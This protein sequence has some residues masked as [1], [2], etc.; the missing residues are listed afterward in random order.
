MAGIRSARRWPSAA[1]AVPAWKLDLEWCGGKDRGRFRKGRCHQGPRNSSARE[2]LPPSSSDHVCST[3]ASAPSTIHWL[4]VSTVVPRPSCP[5][6]GLGQTSVAK[7]PLSSSWDGGILRPW[8]ASA[9][10]VPALPSSSPQGPGLG[11]LGAGQCSTLEGLPPAT[12]QCHLTPAVY[13]L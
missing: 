3:P 8:T 13:Y 12:W 7:V 4:L 6:G 1:A 5:L 11:L 2:A 10:L 9:C